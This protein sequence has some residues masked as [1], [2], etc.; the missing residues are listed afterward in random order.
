MNTCFARDAEEIVVV[1]FL[2]IGPRAVVAVGKVF[3]QK[4]EAIFN[5]MILTRLKRMQFG[6]F[7]P[8][9]VAGG[10]VKVRKTSSLRAQRRTYSWWVR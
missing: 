6:A 10:N 5:F 1:G 2:D 9:Q 4:V 8:L 7:C 3:P